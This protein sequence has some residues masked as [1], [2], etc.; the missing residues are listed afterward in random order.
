MTTMP[1]GKH[2]NTPLDEVPPKYL[3]WVLK[4]VKHLDPD[5]RADINA[6]LKGKPLP[7]SD[8]ERIDALFNDKYGGQT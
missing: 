2:R 5:L 7:K 3:R 8:Y 6:V 4:E 1:F